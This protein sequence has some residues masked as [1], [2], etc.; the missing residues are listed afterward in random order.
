MLL[1]TAPSPNPN[2]AT[3]LRAPGDCEAERALFAGA[4]RPT[5]GTA[6]TAHCTDGCSRCTDDSTDRT[7]RT[8]RTVCSTAP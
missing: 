1:A 4:W 5:T 7:D 2:Q 6:L 8:G 3:R